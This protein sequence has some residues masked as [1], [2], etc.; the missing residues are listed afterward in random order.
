MKIVTALLPSLGNLVWGQLTKFKAWAKDKY[1][2]YKLRILK[3]REEY[4]KAKD[5]QVSMSLAAE[6][7][8]TEAG[9]AAI[10][11]MDAAETFQEKMDALINHTPDYGDTNDTNPDTA[12][13]MPDGP[14]LGRMRID[15]TSSER[16]VDADADHKHD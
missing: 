10:A 1:Y 9:E 15:L 6:A 4:L 16:G 3:S 5:E 12:D 13:G 8:I 14:V 11:E 2:Q 7:E